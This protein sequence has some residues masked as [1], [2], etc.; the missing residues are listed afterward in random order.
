MKISAKKYAVALFQSL[1]NKDEKE[2]KEVVER[3]VKLLATNHH[4]ALGIRI[5]YHLD[6]L[7]KKAGLDLELKCSSA[8]SL[9]KILIDNL[10]KHFQVSIVK[11][12]L[13]QDLIGG[14]ILRYQD[15][16]IDASLKT[17]L[18]NLNNHLKI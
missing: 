4:L 6:Q 18:K 1:K 15:K 11:E 5:I 10:A 8:R 14:I 3:F 7:Y 2:I 13:N 16:I 12:E 17:R 9:N